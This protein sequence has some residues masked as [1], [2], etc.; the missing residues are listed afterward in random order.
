M[1][2]EKTP[3]TL[4]RTPINREHADTEANEA[5]KRL[6]VPGSASPSF[7][8]IPWRLSVRKIHHAGMKNTFL[9]GRI[10]FVITILAAVFT[11]RL[12]AQLTWER[13]VE[14]E[15]RNRRNLQG[16]I[17]N[18]PRSDHAKNID[19][20]RNKLKGFASEDSLWL[21]FWDKIGIAS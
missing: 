3:K 10:Y 2:L 1:N 17:Q 13:A 15:F 21:G 7:E 19:N 11:P 5:R 14:L 6:K 9:L 16:S 12:R 8:G 4:P 18:E 20:L